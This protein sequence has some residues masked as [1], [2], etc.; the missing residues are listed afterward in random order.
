[1]WMYQGAASARAG[2]AMT[3][4]VRMNFGNEPR[5]ACRDWND[6]IVSMAIPMIAAAVN[7][8]DLVTMPRPRAKPIRSDVRSGNSCLIART[9]RY[10]IQL[11]AAITMMSLLTI[12]AS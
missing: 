2:A 9:T 6:R 3:S 10:R 5:N 11:K 4:P 8:V 1:M 12:V 7:E